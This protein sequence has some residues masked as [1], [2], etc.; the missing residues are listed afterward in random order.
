MPSPAYIK[1]EGDDQGL[2]TASANSADS[3]G[4]GN[5]K[6]K[7][8]D[9]SNI[10]AVEHKIFLPT[11]P[12]NGQPSGSRVHKPFMIRKEFDKASPLLYQAL[13]AG[14]RLTVNISWVR[15]EGSE[16]I[17]YFT[18]I[19]TEA[20]LVDMD[21]VVPHTKVVENMPLRHEERWYFAYRKIEWEH[22]KAGTSSSDDW[23]AN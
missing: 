17:E 14:E 20:L 9:Y 4:Q 3:L 18:H 19:L 6:D 11:D 10:L 21:V 5:F 8:G 13:C 2:I 7:W 1:V 23:Q 12:S 15:T 16:E 22:T